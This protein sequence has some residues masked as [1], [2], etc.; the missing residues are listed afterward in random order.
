MQVLKNIVES[1]II[2]PIMSDDTPLH[3]QQEM[4]SRTDKFNKNWFNCLLGFFEHLWRKKQFLELNRTCGKEIERNLGETFSYLSLDRR[5][6]RSNGHP[7]APTLHC[8]WSRS[9][10][11]AWSGRS[12]SPACSLRCRRHPAPPGSG[13]AGLRR[14]QGA[15]ASPS[16]RALIL[17]FERQ[18]K[19]KTMRFVNLKN[20][21]CDEGATSK[22]NEGIEFDAQEPCGW[23]DW[24]CV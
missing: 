21:C 13:A 19:N 5:C 17:R 23:W 24:F 2:S 10:W 22:D 20:A 16:P 14:R 9:E 12:T 3:W 8:T 18:K 6:V 1:R 15:G 4:I 7:G 11:Q